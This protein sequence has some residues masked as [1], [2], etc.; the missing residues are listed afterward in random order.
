MSVPERG[1]PISCR[2]VTK[3]G[4]SSIQSCGIHVGE[5]DYSNHPM[6][7]GTISTMVLNSE[8]KYTKHQEQLLVRRAYLQ[9]DDSDAAIF[10][11][12]HA[13]RHTIPK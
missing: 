12:A 2:E 5:F 11:A 13:E 1:G 6:H 4:G 10:A 3:K 9:V 8:N 7:T